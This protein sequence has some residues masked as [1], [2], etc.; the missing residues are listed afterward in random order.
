MPE[1]ATVETPQGK[2]ELHVC[3]DGDP[4]NVDWVAIYEESFP[5][6]QR[7]PL[8]E[9]KQQLQTGKMELDETRDQT[10]RIL[11]MTVS[12][13]F[14][15]IEKSLSFVLACYTAVVP[16][17]RGLGIGTVHRKKL[18]QLL[19]EEYGSYLGMF[20]EI[21]STK[22]H[23]DDPELA[24]TRVKRKNFFMKLGLIPLD[25]PYRFP[26]YDGS[27]PLEGELLW[28]PFTRDQLHPDELESVVLRIYTE[29]YELK[30]DDSFVQKQL[31]EIKETYSQ[32]VGK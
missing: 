10:G 7:Q 8:D 23:T 12:E 25:V 21:E 29:G 18:E 32:R 31:V 6:D 2:L 28:F 11:C 19:R 5:P 16:K 4:K 13:I 14:R 20:T 17:M 9:L 3:K 22:Q 24:K 1:T 27:E 15:P 30:P 26:S